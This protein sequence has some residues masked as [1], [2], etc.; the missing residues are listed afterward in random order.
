MGKKVTA[1]KRLAGKGLFPPQF[2][3]T[4]LLPI[5]NI[6]LSP[7]AL[8]C[9]LKLEKSFIVL[10]VGPGPGYFSAK[11]ARALP[12]G[13][14]YLS[15][16]QQEML[17]F[18]KKRL[19][20]KNIINVEY[21]L[22]NGTSFPFADGTFDVIYMVTVLGEIANRE[23]YIKEFYRLLR[24]NGIVSIS[25]QSGDPDKMEPAEID[26]LFKNSGFL[27]DGFFGTRR[28]FTLNFRKGS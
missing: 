26:E 6:F 4:L 3:F 25:E 17:D 27:P 16:I 12:E 14:L 28:N 23:Q 24:N 11:I 9:R 21:H 7:K 19:I 18:A 2:A 22:C 5:R 10:E 15:D 13:K 8:I 1:I 20:R